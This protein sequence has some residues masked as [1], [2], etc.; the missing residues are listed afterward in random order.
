MHRFRVWAPRA[1]RV[2][3]LVDGQRYAME[4]EPRDWWMAAVEAAHAGSRYGFLL[5]DDEKPLPDPRSQRQ[6]EGVHGL[7]ALVDHSAFRWSDA[8]WRSPA[9][10]SAVIYELH[11]GTFTP[12]ST[13]DAAI[14]RLEYLRELG[15]THISL[16]PLASAEGDRGWGYDGVA[17]YAPLE[18]YGGPDA[19]KRFVDA[20]HARGLAVLI[21]VVYNHFGPSGNYSGRF[22]PYITDHHKTPWG[23][24]VNFEDAGSAE[25]REFFI[26]NALMWLRDYH[27]DGLRVDA[28]HAFIDRSA[29]HFLEQLKDAVR[30]LEN[31]T[32][33][34]YVV[35]AESD[36]NDPRLVTAKEA[37]GYGL[38]AQWSDDFHH[39]LWTVLTD[40]SAG[41]YADFGAIAQLAKAIT[42]VFVYQGQ[43]SC[44][45]KRNHGRPVVGLPADRFLGYIQNH[46]QVGNRAQG[47]RLS[48]VVDVGRLKI[49]A[50]LVVL[51]PFV[52]MLFAG[53]EFAASTPFQYF[54]DFHDKELG[55]AVSEG[56]RKEFVAF[57]WSPQE[58]PDPQAEETV[59][60]S[61]LRWDELDKG[62]H[63]EVLDWYRKLITL[64]HQ[65]IALTSPMLGDVRVRFDEER[66]WLWMTR[67]P[68]EVVLNAGGSDVVLPASQP[69]QMALAS[70]SGVGVERQGLRLPAASVAVLR[71]PEFAQ[72]RAGNMTG[73]LS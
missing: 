23:G 64:R 66:K 58:V 32:G 2:S 19:V 28:V 48:H 46:D 14:S 73:D 5:D 33:R 54:T 7:S 63:A 16:M 56:R 35:I 15:V 39:A 30:T 50:A 67:G 49:A 55:R 6:P 9:L 41:Y 37:G 47:D 18:A 51:G 40:E 36:L 44:Y 20:A 21:D 70:A 29:I 4:Q 71:N 69:Y 31:H 59:L 72:W 34:P 3:V 17:L 53:E 11:V 38:D 43:Y 25:V 52:P 57:G 1:K 12:E 62:T 27:F 68:I 13:L 24:A 22:G 26:D 65:E 45:R 10:G 8:G 61:K 42:E 60:H